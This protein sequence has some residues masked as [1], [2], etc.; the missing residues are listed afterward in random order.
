[1]K[2]EK[3]KPLEDRRTFLGTVGAAAVTVS[4]LS[5]ANAYA[6]DIGPQ[7]G[8]QRAEQAEPL[9]QPGAHGADGSAERS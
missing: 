5:A 1:M 9:W 4:V 3:E 7:G 8:R 2:N 6:D